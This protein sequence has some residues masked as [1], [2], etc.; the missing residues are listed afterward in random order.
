VNGS[1][2]DLGNSDYNGDNSSGGGLGDCDNN[3]GDNVSGV[4]LGVG[5]GDNSGCALGGNNGGG[6]SDCNGTVIYT[7]TTKEQACQVP[8]E[9]I[10]KTPYEKLKEQRK[11]DI[12]NM[13]VESLSSLISNYTTT[14]DGARELIEGMLGSTKFQTNFGNV[15]K[16]ESGLADFM[17]L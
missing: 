14:D 12:R 13:C 16:K 15:F 6:R 1:G 2:G 3:Y 5:G 17:I 10:C 4:G 7:S 8:E 9:T 11:R